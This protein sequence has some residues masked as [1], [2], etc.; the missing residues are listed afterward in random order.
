MNS[1]RSPLSGGTVI[2][3]GVFLALMVLLMAAMFAPIAAQADEPPVA[4]SLQPVGQHGSYF[5]LTLKP[6]ETRQLQVALLDAGTAPVAALTYAADVRTLANGGLGAETAGVAP[7]ATTTWL[8]YPSTVETLQPG[9]AVDRGFTV[10]VPSGTRAG[11]YI[12]SLVLENADATVQG[13]IPQIVRTVI[14]V[15]IRVPGALHP[16]ASIGAITVANSAGSAQVRAVVANTGSAMLKP[17]VT[18]KLMDANG[19]QVWTGGLAMGS[20]YMHTRTGIDVPIPSKYATGAYRVDVSLA[21]RAGHLLATGSMPRTP[22]DGFAK[23]I[24]PLSAVLMG[25]AFLILVLSIVL[26]AVT[27]RRGRFESET[28][29]EA[30]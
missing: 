10:T 17:V 28:V 5:E 23:H 19:T 1:L 14:A 22:A 29:V 13:G 16:A 9:S 27:G 25:A 26:A 4:L 3:V 18:V 24:D 7:T 21:D 2:V 15:S 30:S 12:S 20:F 11:Q 8:A 6:G